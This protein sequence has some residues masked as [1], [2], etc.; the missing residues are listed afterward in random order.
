[1]LNVMLKIG[2]MYYL[3][4][5]FD[6]AISGSRTPRAGAFL[7]TCHTISVG[8]LDERGVIRFGMYESHVLYEELGI[9]DPKPTEWTTV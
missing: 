2:M 9:V 7:D 1:M 5:A 3:P 6:V 8:S 4:F